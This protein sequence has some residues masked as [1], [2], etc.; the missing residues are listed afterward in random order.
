MANAYNNP[1]TAKGG[2][3]YQQFGAHYSAHIQA[4]K[5]HDQAL[6]AA[7]DA[8]TK[9]KSASVHPSFLGRAFDD[10]NA[11]GQGVG[12][13]VGKALPE[14]GAQV[15]RAPSLARF[16]QPILPS[17]IDKKIQRNVV[18]PTRRASDKFMKSDVVRSATE[19]NK[20]DIA[21]TKKAPGAEKAGRFVGGA[22]VL[23]GEAAAP[24]PK[25]T[26]IIR[27]AQ[28]GK[29]VKGLASALGTVAET[30]TK[31][32]QKSSKL[33]GAIVKEAS[34]PVTDP[35]KLLGTAKDNRLAF[36][37]NKL[38]ELEKEKQAILKDPNAYSTNPEDLRSLKGEKVGRLNKSGTF[39]QSSGATIT[40]T[41]DSVSRLRDIMKEQRFIRQH[42][43]EI[44]A[45]TPDIPT[46]VKHTDPTIGTKTGVNEHEALQSLDTI[47]GQATRPSGRIARTKQG[48]SAALGS[49]VTAIRSI[50]TKS[51]KVLADRVAAVTPTH[52]ALRSDYERQIPTVLKLKGQ[53]EANFFDHVEKGAAPMNDKVKQAGAEWKKLSPTVRQD[54]LNANVKV[55]HQMNFLPHSYDWNAIEKNPAQ[56]DKILQNI[57]KNGDAKNITEARDL[58]DTFKN[59]TGGPNR[60]GHFEVSRKLNIDG[61]RKDVHTVRN[62]LDLAA[63]RTAEATHLGANNEHAVQ[64]INA[65]RKEKGNHIT[66][67]DAVKYFLHAPDT[68]GALSRGAGK[69]RSVYGAARL[70]TAAIAHLSQP[71][72][73]IVRAGTKNTVKALAHIASP[74]HWKFARDSGVIHPNELHGLIEQQT[75]VEGKLGKVTAPVLTPVMRMGRVLAANA[76]REYGNALARSGKLDELKRL[77]VQGEIQ[78]GK[79]S[80]EQE[81]QAARGV[82]NDT[83]F[84][85]SRGA[86]PIKAETTGGKLAGQYRLA[87]AY[88]QTGF[89]YKHVLQEAKR[90]NIKP[91]A[92]YIAL[93]APLAY[94][95][96]TA[97]R[98]ISGSQEGPGGIALDTL[99]ALGGLP[100]ELAMQS[101]R[102]GKKYPAETI[103]GA[104]APVA[105]EAFKLGSALDQVA[106][107]NKKPAGKY[108][109]GL[110]P[111]EGK[112]VSAKIFPSGS[113]TARNITA[114][115]NQSLNTELKRLQYA[116]ADSD[117][118]AD[119]AKNL[120]EHDFQL[121]TH[122]SSTLFADR[123]AKA[124]SDSSYQALSD[125][126]KKKQMSSILGGARK[127]VLD[128]MIGKAKRSTTKKFKSYR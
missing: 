113:H 4:G 39:A 43:S 17:S 50:G 77:G 56:Y 18:A 91:L 89:I 19:P 25:V 11:F 119:R 116:P 58:V 33:G 121:Y 41:K 24:T 86:T 73:V 69:V 125:A 20:Y 80:K 110:V 117:R 38:A 81:F 95:S 76:G 75:G 46:T 82:T 92:R 122:A 120:G 109:A 79:L 53:E 1:Y 22:D 70:G 10:I 29:Q 105:G 61:Y 103:A 72:N 107:G 66:A 101:V 14:L 90:G 28:R 21:T 34:K 96:T 83:Y 88:K 3:A 57:V 112:N 8:V 26:S 71:G 30:G 67:R 64:L 55:G 63:K 126:D 118:K 23:L 123:A 52:Q 5:T 47:G 48:F 111:V 106:R 127:D 13:V 35:A 108:V 12:T 128:Q 6:V 9:A 54:A 37:N 62:Y 31:Q 114:E 98:K 59:T 60:F 42:I 40:S 15:I 100:G 2:N 36:H 16:A 87:Y 85:R 65:I 115:G 27:G 99:G 94:G 49:K 84:N 68:S 93:S 7:H 97:R 51:A 44:K 45:K 104:A 124:L 102:Y 78:G 74:S 32:A